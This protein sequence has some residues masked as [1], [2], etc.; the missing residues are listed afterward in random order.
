[1][2]AVIVD[3]VE[4]AG[5]PGD[6]GGVDQDVDPPAKGGLGI[7][8]Q[9]LHCG[10]LSG[11]RGQCRRQLTAGRGGGAHVLEQPFSRLGE[12]GA[13]EVADDDADAFVQE[14]ARRFL[15]DAAARSGDQCRAS[16]DVQIHALIPTHRPQH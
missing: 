12:L 2:P 3:L 1:V 9:P 4:G 16:C 10:G 13:V 11:I 5:G 15:P 14:L 8:D 6:A 7:S